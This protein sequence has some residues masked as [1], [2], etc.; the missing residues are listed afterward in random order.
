VAVTAAPPGELGATGPPRSPYPGLRPFTE[1]DAAFFYGRAA[2][3]EIVAANLLSSRLTLVYGASGVGKTSVLLAGVANTLRRQAEANLDDE[4]EFN[5]FAVVVMSSWADPDPNRSIAAAAR[6]EVGALLG[7]EDLRDPPDGATLAEVLGHW[8]DQLGGKLLVV[9]DQFEDYFRYHHDDR[10]AGTFD[11]EFPQ[12]VNGVDVPVHF[13]LAVR[14]DELAR[15]DHF[16]GRIPKLFDNRVKIDHLTCPGAERAIRRPLENLP[17]AYPV[18]IEDELVSA[19]LANCAVRDPALAADSVGADGRPAVVKAPTGSV[20]APLLQL[21]LERLWRAAL[22]DGAAEDAAEQDGAGEGGAVE[23]G[24]VEGGAVESGAVEGGAV[25]GGA[26][27]GGAVDGGART[28]TLAQLESLGGVEGILDTH[29]RTALDAFS[30]LE[31]DV[32]AKCFGLLVSPTKTKL[33]YPASVLARVA[34]RDD[35]REVTA[36]LDALCS[37]DSGHILNAVDTGQDGGSK[38]YEISNAD[39]LTE[40]IVAWQKEH[41]EQ[42]RREAEEA[43]RLA[44]RRKYRNRSIILGTLVAI[45]AALG[46]WA[47]VQR[48]EAKDAARAAASVALASTADQQLA[49]HRDV[50]L[51]LS[52]E[53]YNVKP[54]PQ[55]ESSVI[56]ALTAVRRSGATI[57]RG[58]QGGVTAVTFGGAGNMLAAAGSDGTV[59]LWDGLGRKL[60]RQLTGGDHGA[61]TAV[62]LS[63]DRHTLAAGYDDGAILLWDL[64]SHT[65]HPLEP[66]SKGAVTSLAF[67][68]KG[69]RVSAADSDGWVNVWNARTRKHLGAHVR[70][71]AMVLSPLG[72]VLR[73]IR[74]DFDHVAIQ[75]WV[76]A[77]S[78]WR[79]E[80][81]RKALTVPALI[82]AHAYDPVGPTFA[83]A[84]DSGKV[85]LWHLGARERGKVVRAGKKGGINS[86]AFSQDGETLATAGSDGL[87]HLFDVH[88]LALSPHG[89]PLNGHQ[90]AVSSVTFNAGGKTLAAGYDDGTVLLWP[91]RARSV[92]TGGKLAKAFADSGSYAF[93]SDRKTLALAAFTEDEVQLWDTSRNA[94]LRSLPDRQEGLSDI[95]FSADGL[96]LA[97]AGYDGTVL[98]WDVAR[99]KRLPNS[100]AIRDRNVYLVMFSPDGKTLVT[101]DLDGTLRLWDWRTGRKTLGPMNGHQ[102]YVGQVAFSPDGRS[103][104]A[105]NS[106]GT[107]L[108][109]DV[110]SEKPVGKALYV[111]RNGVGAVAFSPTEPT[112]LATGGTDGTVLLWDTKRGTRLLMSGNQREVNDVTFSP[113][114]RTVASAGEDGTVVLFN[115][116]NHIRQRLNGNQ[117]PVLVVAFNPDGTALTTLGDNGKVVWSAREMKM[118]ADPKAEVCTLVAGNLTEVQWKAL[119]PPGRDYHTTCAAS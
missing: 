72:S 24:A 18:G 16:K 38:S 104:A 97:T 93:S 115:L 54:T 94:L 30:P 76:F 86:V 116:D 46:A 48:N 15:L 106:N 34:G 21:V 49:D 90:G 2:E 17:A 101:V 41:D 113:D 27:E 108:V 55:A 79:H 64:R 83:A 53:A 33:A 80:A 63:G 65:W 1:K 73:T 85:Q 7:R 110:T 59:N 32:A 91:L 109:W 84:Y 100:P 81:G 36:V 118:P 43:R 56:S 66:S 69:E 47:W 42:R 39:L 22:E 37:A 10:R 78:K 68:G 58:N 62:A 119:A 35:E 23:G 6:A 61:V 11:A 95:A 28:L 88:D 3:V 25:E 67:D 51:L 57:L 20:K 40:P 114:G 98:L 102:G 19:L 60:G 4:D 77:G 13:L 111:S 29:L 105:V 45:F 52:L 44:I 75:E 70:G 14:D 99:G 50:A 89:A 107:V 92:N 26:V 31:Q 5:D 112:M 74:N 96:T 8:S 87:V 117:G 71:D 103:L 12:A 82:T 9:F